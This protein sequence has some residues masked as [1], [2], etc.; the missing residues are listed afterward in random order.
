[1]CSRM[2]RLT[3][4]VFTARRDTT[5]GKEDYN[6]IIIDC[7]RV[8]KKKF[9][10]IRALHKEQV[11]TVRRSTSSF[12]CLLLL[13]L[14]LQ[15]RRPPRNPRNGLHVYNTQSDRCTLLLQRGKIRFLELF[16]RGNSRK[17]VC[18]TQIRHR[19]RGHQ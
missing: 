2:A 15:C 10:Y 11:Y 5:G 13:L 1:M 6:I 12:Y 8:I 9:V 18:V 3:I 7:V 4:F 14:L 17:C 16:V 19:T